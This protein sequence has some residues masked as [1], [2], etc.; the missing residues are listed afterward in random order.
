MDIKIREL[1]HRIEKVILQIDG[2]REKRFVIYTNG[3][4]GKAVK[5]YLETEFHIVP[6]YVID[7]KLYNGL[8]ILSLE[9]AKCRDNEGVF[10]LVC[11]WNDDFYIE[12]RRA[13]YAAFP[14]NQIIDIFP[15]KELPD[16]KEI[17]LELRHIKAYCEENENCH[18]FIHLE[19]ADKDDWGIKKEYADLRSKIIDFTERE[20]SL[21][22]VFERKAFAGAA[23]FLMNE[24]CISND[25]IFAGKI[26]MYHHLGMLPDGIWEE[27]EY[28]KK[29]DKSKKTD[30]DLLLTAE[31]IGLFTR[32]P[33]GHVVPA[34]D[35]LI[36]EGIAK[37]IHRI[38]CCMAECAVD[39]KHFYKSVYVLFCAMQERILKYAQ[40]AK[41]CYEISGKENLKRIQESCEWIANYPPRNLYEA[42]QLLILAHEHILMEEWSGSISFGRL[43]QYLYPFYEKDLRESKITKEEAQD[44]FVALWRKIAQYEMGWQNVT[45]GGSDRNGRDMCN[46]LTI[47]CLNASLI[48][49]ADQPQV[50]LRIHKNM[51]EYIWEKAFELIGAGMG[52][53]E[54]YNDEIA[55]QAKMN[56]GI[57]EE[58]AW[59]YS[60]VG[61]VELSVGGREYSHTEGARI[62][63]AKIL[64]LMLNS[65]SCSLTGLTWQLSEKHNLDDIK[66]FSEFYEWYKRELVF[67]TE[68]ICNSIDI[69]SRQ[70]AKYWPMPFLSGMM[71]GCIENGRDVADCGTIYNNLSINCVGIA[72]VADSL[73]A[74]DTLVYKDKVI[75]LS[76]LADLLSNN[77]KSDES[78]RERMLECPKY[79]NDILS[80]DTKVKD[81]VNLFVDTLTN[82]PIKSREGKF[83]AGFY[84]SYFHDSMGKLTGALPDGRKAKEALSASLSPMAGMDKNGPTAVVNSVNRINMSHLSN[85]MVFDLKFTSDFFYEK[86]HQWAVRI[87]I[88]EYFERGGSEIQFNV[89]DRKTLLEAQKNPWEYQNL[90]VRVSGFSA[91][92]VNLDQSLQNEIIKRTEYGFS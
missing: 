50:T 48:V 51:P 12:I 1:K 28:V 40:K 36:Q 70:Y 39:K 13:I 26:G 33:G 31:K 78:I 17:R 92:F 24:V 85:G 79:G 90:I 80:V 15:K 34:Y 23:F 56:A 9:Q 65:G 74:I 69:L 76:K 87:L 38:C 30:L 52:F 41:E 58:D 16:D 20:L 27:I 89:V 82:M 73:E 2:I 4:G 84:T 7:N 72:S 55:V 83:Q 54:L 44:L 35:E 25:D 32:S 3:I 5:K 88:E 57:S 46:D 45:L 19:T 60:I 22:P 8:D 6:E 29:T 77:F 42:M 10:F 81:L 68:Y 43:D 64:E 75:S 86:K 37:R 91:Y 14:K 67:F 47:F 61:C 62:N 18:A 53:P 66:D 59:N 49:R 63:W 11:S 71:R 21:K